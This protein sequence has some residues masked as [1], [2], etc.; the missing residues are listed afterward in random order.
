V[1][2]LQGS[3]PRGSR[4]RSAKTRRGVLMRI[5]VIDLGELGSH[6]VYKELKVTQ[7]TYL[8]GYKAPEV[9]A[10]AVALP[11]SIQRQEG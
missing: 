2:K 7:A 10:R 8:H 1:Q 3:N 6:K 9:S 4:A 11:I 5:G